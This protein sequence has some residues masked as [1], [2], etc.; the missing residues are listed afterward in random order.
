MAGGKRSGPNSGKKSEEKMEEPPS[1]G[2]S[3]RKKKGDQWPWWMWAIGG[4]ALLVCVGQIFDSKESPRSKAA[5][6]SGKKGKGGEMSTERYLELALRLQEMTEIGSSLNNVEALDG[7]VAQAMNKELE[8]IEGELE[9]AG[10]KIAR[11][12]LAMVS[13]VR[14]TLYQKAENLTDEQVQELNKSWTYANPNYWDD[15]YN[16]TSEE[17]RFDWYGSWDTKVQEVT[18]ESGEEKKGAEQQLGDLLKPYMPSGKPQILMLGC[19]NSDMSEKMYRQGYENILNVDISEN[20]LEKL[21]EKLAASTPGMRWQYANAS[22]LEFP[23][24]AFD[25]TMDKGTFDALE[26]NKPLVAAAFKETHRTLRKGG[27]LI[28]V[29]FNPASQRVDTQL[30]ESDDWGECETRVFE[31]P[32]HKS[33]YHI[34]ACKRKE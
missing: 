16:R 25:V 33:R 1:G 30:R 4:L 26:H 9:G 21:R 3:K 14:G 2:S 23:D 7:E 19:G 27:T 10:G 32:E 20:L 29:T 31:R 6:K 13:V 15:Y 28:S 34:H 24:E 11:D 8:E 5:G 18:T 22:A 12:L 17:E